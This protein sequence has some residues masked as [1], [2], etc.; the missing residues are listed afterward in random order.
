MNQPI[1]RIFLFQEHRD[2]LWILNPFLSYYDDTVC[3]I[4]YFFV[5]SFHVALIM[6]G[7]GRWAINQG[8]PRIWGHQQGA[9]TLIHILRACPEHHITHV[10]IYAFSPEN[11]N[12]HADEVHALM[13]LF[14]IYL[15]VY[16]G[17]L[18][19]EKI[20]LRVIGER[21][22]LPKT[23][24]NRIK[25]TEEK[26]KKHQGLVLQVALNYGGRDDMV[27][28]TQQIVS[29]YQDQRLNPAHLT[30]EEVT[31]ALWSES[32]P[33]P[34][35]LIRTGGEMRLSNF[36]LWQLCYTELIFLPQYW[37]DFTPK[38]LGQAIAQFHGRQRRFGRIP[39]EKNPP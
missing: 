18:D 38:D 1:P 11:W 10:T 5:S 30:R 19:R 13:R 36:M 29:R 34:D 9:K 6:D 17:E 22:G 14:Q 2:G 16:S 39:D 7:N 37:P 31:S 32:C 8:K 23:L 33:D 3:V 25:K 12:R 27:Q 28:A 20:Q 35:L 24:Q 21:S 26:T 15:R 4:K